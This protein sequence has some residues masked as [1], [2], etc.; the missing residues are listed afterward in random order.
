MPHL[1]DATMFWTANGGGVRRYLEAKHAFASSAHWRHSVATPMVDGIS[2]VRIPALPLPASGGYRLPWRRAAAARMLAEQAPDLIEAGDAYRLAWSVL[3]AGQS[4][5]IPALA[6]CH[7]NLPL[8]AATL[9]GARI[10]AGAARAARRYA[11]RLY[12]QFD[13]VLAPSAT[14]CAH[15]RDW[16]VKRVQHQPL[17]VDSAVFHPRRR[18]PAWRRR[19]GLPDD[20]RVLVYAGRF[21]PEKNLPVLTAAVRLLGPPYWL[22]AVG[23]GPTPPQGDRVMVLAPERR[24]EALATLVASADAFVHA[25]DQETFGLSVLEALACGTP[26]VARA[27]EGLAELVDGRVGIAVGRTRS[28]DFAEAIAALFGSVDRARFAQAAR[29]RGEAHDWQQTL[30]RLWRQYDRLL[31]RY[32]AVEALPS[33]EPA[34]AR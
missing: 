26:V 25:G 31:K 34:A 29:A 12:R 17:G 32:A 2:S 22:V 9:A 30:P 3:D 18:D 13:L 27:A 8:L 19:V 5:G 23:A 4:L 6:F 7:S 15:L 33:P 11:G 21:A 10:G 28:E 14:M 24:P 1:L 20:A 16:G